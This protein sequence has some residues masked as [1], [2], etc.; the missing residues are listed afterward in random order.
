VDFAKQSC[1]KEAVAWKFLLSKL[2][3]PA[4]SESDICDWTLVEAVLEH[5]AAILQPE[6]FLSIIP[7]DANLRYTLNILVVSRRETSAH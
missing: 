2:L 6:E 7:D 1:G 4:L 3:E 5:A